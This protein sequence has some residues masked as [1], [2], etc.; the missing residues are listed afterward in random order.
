LG[1]MIVD[2]WLDP[3]FSI[4]HDAA[5]G[6]NAVPL[7]DEA[8]ARWVARRCSDGLGRAFRRQTSRGGR[9]GRAGGLAEGWRR[10]D[11]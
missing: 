3:Q 4:G 11:E 7:F 10:G 9:L 1:A 6:P 5:A 2:K 8:I